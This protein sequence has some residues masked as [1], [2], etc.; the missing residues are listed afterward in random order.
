VRRGERILPDVL[1]CRRLE[2]GRG[3]T[4][5][6]VQSRS[7][8]RRMWCGR[9]RAPGDRCRGVVA[10]RRRPIAK[11]QD[12]S[13]SHRSDCKRASRP[14]DHGVVSMW[15]RTPRRHGSQRRRRCAYRRRKRQ[16]EDPCACRKVRKAS[17]ALGVSPSGEGAEQRTTRRLDTALT[18]HALASSRNND[19]CQRRQ[20]PA[21]IAGADREI[22]AD[23]PFPRVRRRRRSQAN[24][25]A[26]D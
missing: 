12:L 19:R 16:D 23:C 20:P 25:P 8:N 6:R 14:F 3:E 7:L 26:Q 13:P 10:A 11:E 2:L 1:C 21:A 24:L 5:G 17:A 4:A 18:T 9:P 15:V 22:D